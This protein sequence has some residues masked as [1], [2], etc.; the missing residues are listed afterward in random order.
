MP[1][2]QKL[3]QPTLKVNIN[4]NFEPTEAMIDTGA[5]ISGIE[6]SLATSKN[7]VIQLESKKVIQIFGGYTYTPY[8]ESDVSVNF[9]GLN[10]KIQLSVM[11]KTITPLLL[12]T[13][14]IAELG[15]SGLFIFY[16]RN[17]GRMVA[18]R[19]EPSYK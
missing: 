10:T 9:D 1:L 14:W 5:T 12:G 18:Q 4:G 6:L 3:S 2:I 16:D 13:D 17:I 7:C 15:D 8:G 11:D 19:N